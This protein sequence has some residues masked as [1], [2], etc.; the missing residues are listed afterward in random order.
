MYGMDINNGKLQEEIQ[1][2][3]QLLEE[4]IYENI[5]LYFENRRLRKK[6]GELKRLQSWWKGG[7]EKLQYRF[8]SA[9]VEEES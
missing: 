9:G 2:E 7:E 8:G 3:K 1:V 5:M 4:L 6:L